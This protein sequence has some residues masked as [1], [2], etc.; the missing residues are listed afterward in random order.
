MKPMRILVVN[1]EYPPVGGGGGEVSRVLSEGFALRGHQVKVLTSRWGILP[2]AESPRRGL[3]IQRIFAFRKSADHCTPARM[4]AFAL[5][6]APRAVGVAMNFLPD[7][8]HCHFAVPVAPVG[9]FVRLIERVPFIVT[10]HG[11]DVPGHQPQETDAWF[12]WIRRPMGFILRKAFACA[13][14]SHHLAE[15]ARQGYGLPEVLEIPNGVDSDFFNPRGA[16]SPRRD[17]RIR[18][19]FA[20]RFSPE[21]T[22][23]VLLEAIAIVRKNFGLDVHLSLVG[24]GP[25]EQNLRRRIQALGLGSCVAVTGWVPREMV[26]A[27]LH[28]SDIFVLPSRIEG[29]PMACLQAMAAG[30]PIVASRN[31]G[32]LE[33]VREGENGIFAPVGDAAALADGIARLAGDPEMRRRMAARSREIAWADFRWDVIIDRYLDLFESAPRVR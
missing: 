24:A 21:K 9:W 27:A 3:D 6:A 2:R 7:V 15:R 29:M 32:A 13:A 33:V 23:H 25:E 14:V 5:L 26:A 8:V 12:R 28:S 10:M 20:G 18:C 11:G 22:L 4:A 19:V 17:N 30:L 1:Y 31:P 16:P